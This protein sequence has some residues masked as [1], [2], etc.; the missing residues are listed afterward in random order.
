MTDFVSF[1]GTIDMLPTRKRKSLAREQESQLL[2]E[3]CWCKLKEN[4][5]ERTTASLDTPQDKQA[6]HYREA[7]SPG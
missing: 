6:T 4:L 7:G 1:N 5:S 2:R 3:S